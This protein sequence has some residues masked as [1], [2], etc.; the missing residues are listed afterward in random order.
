M[1]LTSSKY[2][3]PCSSLE[4]TTIFFLCKNIFQHHTYTHVCLWHNISCAADTLASLVHNHYVTYLLCQAS[5]PK[6]HRQLVLS[7]PKVHN[8]MPYAC[9]QHQAPLAAR[10]VQRAFWVPNLYLVSSVYKHF[11]TYLYFFLP[12]CKITV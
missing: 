7:A 11:N 6:A 12:Y 3:L 8:F 5:V 10:L 1:Q 9:H 4:R 2:F